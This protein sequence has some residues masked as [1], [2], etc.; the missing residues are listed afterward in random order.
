MPVLEEN[1]Q[2][3]GESTAIAR[4]LGRKYGKNE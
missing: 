3:L 4:Y 1:G 2:F